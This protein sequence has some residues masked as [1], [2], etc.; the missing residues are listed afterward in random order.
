MFLVDGIIP[1]MKKILVLAVFLCLALVLVFSK[2]NAGSNSDSKMQNSTNKVEE[3]VLYIS[4]SCEFCKEVE[5]WLSVRPEI[6]TR[7]GLIIKEVSS[8]QGNAKDLLE[9][10]K[11]CEEATTGGVNVPFLYSNGQCFVGESEIEKHLEDNYL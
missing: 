7:S 5:D 6:A 11:D 1:C 8:D 10:A 4:E 2:R 3:T 9:R